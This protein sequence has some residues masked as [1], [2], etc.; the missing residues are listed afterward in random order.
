MASDDWGVRDRN[1]RHAPRFHEAAIGV[2]YAL[3]ADRICPMPRSHAVKFLCDP[4]FE[5]TDEHGDVQRPVTKAL[6]ATGGG[7][8]LRPGQIIANPEE[9]TTPALLLRASMIPGAPENLG[10][11]TARE[12]LINIV[13]SAASPSAVPEEDG[14]IEDMDD[15]EIQKMMPDSDLEGQ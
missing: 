6:P 5:V 3:T 10:A 8:I 15:Q 2:V 1:A 13:L 4:A 12:R 14:D 11:A 9:L 7:V